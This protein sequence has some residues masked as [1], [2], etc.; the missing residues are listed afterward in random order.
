MEAYFYAKI[1]PIKCVTLSKAAPP[2]LGGTEVGIQHFAENVLLVTLPEQPQQDDELEEVSRILSEKVDHDV[3]V[4]FS[5]VELLTSET[6]CRLMILDRLLR[7]YGRVL[8]LYNVSSE[9]KHVFIR[10]GLETVFEFAE[11]E[12]AAFRHIRSASRIST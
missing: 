3:M 7:G 8:I 4:D 6:L 1:I 12:L 11:D 9:I 10:T 2:Q 5:G